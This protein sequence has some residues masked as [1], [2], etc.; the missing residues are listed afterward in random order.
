MPERTRTVPAG[1]PA[2]FDVHLDL[3]DPRVLARAPAL[4]PAVTASGTA[5]QP[6]DME[7]AHAPTVAPDIVGFAGPGSP[8]AY[9]VG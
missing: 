5:D 7:M 4:Q 8:Y 1:G 9:N 2:D 6:V 3:P